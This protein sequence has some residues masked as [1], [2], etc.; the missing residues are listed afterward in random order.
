MFYLQ[1]ILLQ[2]TYLNPEETQQ[3]Y[4]KYKTEDF[5]DDH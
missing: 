2:K 5:I 1:N 4:Q 3:E